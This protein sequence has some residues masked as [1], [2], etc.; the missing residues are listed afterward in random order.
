M[1][2]RT[3]SGTRADP[4]GARR[5]GR[6]MARRRRQALAAA[7]IALLAGV[8]VAAGVTLSGSTPVAAGAG[9]GAEGE[10]PTALGKHLEALKRAAPGLQGMAEEGP[11]SAADAAFAARAYPDSTIAVSDVQAARAAWT[12]QAGRPF[13]SGKGRPGTWVAVGPSRALYP[14]TP[15]RNAFN[16][17]PA[18]Y[19]AGGRTTDVA[20]ADTCTPGD[21]RIYVTPA[22]GGVWTT[23]NALAGTPKWEYLGGPLGINAAGSVTI[24]ANDPTGQTIY[25]GTGEAN[26]CGS[27]C[28]AGVGMYRSTDGGKSFTLLGGPDNALKGKGIGEILIEPGA[29]SVIY[30]ATTTA[31]RGMS[32]VCCTGVTRPVPGS[33]NWGLYKSTDGGA[34]WRFLHNGG[35]NEAACAGDTTEF[36]NGD[37]ECS[38]RG[39][40]HIALDPNDATR[41][42]LYASSYA[43]GI[44]RSTDGGESWAQIKLPLINTTTNRAAI[45]VN[46]LPGGATRMYVYE[47]FGG[48]NPYSRLFRSD[49]ANAA[50]PVFQDLTSPSTADPGFA[51]HNICEP[52]CWYDMFVHSP[53]GHPDIVYAGGDYSYGETIANKR[54]VILSTDAG[55][56]GTDMTFDGTDEL[57]PNG[58]HP[59]QHAIAT[60]P[61]NPFQFFE[62]NDGGVMRSSGEFVDRSEW[63]DDPNRGLEGADEARC[64][65]M[66]SRIPSRLEGLNDGLSTLQWI[67]VK[68]SPHDPQLLQGGT[69]DNGTWETPGNPVKWDNTMIGDGGWNGFDVALPDFRFHSFFDVSPDVN[70]DGGDIGKWIW[71]ADPI[72]GHPGSQFYSPIIGDPVTTK[73]MFAGTGLG[74]YRTKTHGLGSM[75]YEEAQRRCN[76]WTGAFDAP[77]GDW[78]K[79]DSTALDGA[80]FGADKLD[81]AIAAVERTAA[82]ATT[83]W[84]AT[85]AGRVFVTKNVGAEPASAVSWTRLDDDHPISPNRFVSSI[86][87]DPANANQAWVS[88][89]GYEVNDPGRPGHIFKVVYDPGTGTSTWTDLSFDFGDLPVNDLVRDD[90]TGDLYAGTDFGVSRLAGGTST[91]TASAPGLPAVEVTSLEVL[92]AER[93]LYAATHGLSTWRLNLAK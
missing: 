42:T 44:W 20:I 69:Q 38:P 66:L 1:G 33:G 76:E 16:Y 35:V 25:V 87:V 89:S 56:S 49:N 51:W 6:D 37:P 40:R 45:A 7:A 72:F 30:A 60:N 14:A 67:K 39:V 12:S 3:D 21:C 29:P 17:V 23:R 64:E 82:D 13:P 57:H 84:A 32:E 22:G 85:T 8:A 52:Q 61:S 24:D 63:C 50:A 26:I 10:V 27:G 90:V 86:Y 75:S 47:G 31:L 5:E 81:G 53:E 70:F 43:R 79:I 34:T 46:A 92:P 48:G 55:V 41:Q 91:W 88:Y 19:V 36:N 93:I 15:F 83:A 65:Q 80:G 71:I 59:D 62:T 58:L 28:V 4:R 2:R 74:V 18:A 54:A 77:C 11:A 68:A 78:V 9:A 73:W